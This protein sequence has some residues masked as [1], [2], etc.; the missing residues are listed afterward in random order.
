MIFGDS[1]LKNAQVNTIVRLQP[2]TRLLAVASRPVTVSVGDTCIGAVGWQMV[3]VLLDGGSIIPGVQMTL[4]FDPSQI[5]VGKV[6]K[7]EYER[8]LIWQH[9]GAHGL[10]TLVGCS[11]GRYVA[12]TSFYLSVPTADEDAECSVRT[13]TDVKLE[14]AATRT[15]HCARWYHGDRQ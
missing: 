9:Q 5:A 14:A 13:L 6:V 1:S 3:P 8:G 12:G 10:C 7:T 15:R 11:P 2:A 4:T